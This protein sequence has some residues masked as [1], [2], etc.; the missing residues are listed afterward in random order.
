MTPPITADAVA[1]AIRPGGNAIRFFRHAA[2]SG[3][4]IPIT[5]RPTSGELQA[6]PVSDP[7][8]CDQ[9]G[10]NDESQHAGI[11]HDRGIARCRV[12][13]L[14]PRHQLATTL[15]QIVFTRLI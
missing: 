7:P 8:V 10:Q 6:T 3:D 11:G 4:V 15:A 14:R 12:F 13:G 2:H 5:H 9:D 1:H